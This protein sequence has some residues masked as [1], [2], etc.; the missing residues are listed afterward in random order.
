MSWPK[1]PAHMAS[2]V[3]LNLTC[4]LPALDGTSQH[5]PRMSLHIERFRKRLLTED[6]VYPH[7]CCIIYYQYTMTHYLLPLTLL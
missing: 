5:S 3:G 6:N 1:G 7:E 4:K 2:E